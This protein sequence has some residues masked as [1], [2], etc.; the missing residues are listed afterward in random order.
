MPGNIIRTQ[1]EKDEQRLTTLIRES[2]NK[3]YYHDFSHK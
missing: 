1:K 2:F 3:V